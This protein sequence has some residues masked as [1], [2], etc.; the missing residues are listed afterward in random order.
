MSERQN[1]PPTTQAC[2]LLKAM[3]NERRL[4]VL[5]HLLKGEH[6]VNELCKLVGLSQSALSQHLAKL[7]RDR[8]VKTRRAAQTIYYSIA[9]PEVGQIV[10]TLQDLYAK[11]DDNG[12][13]GFI[14][15]PPERASVS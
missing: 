3:S 7:R 9:A 14:D 1:L 4:I 6:S 5:C 2:Q 10:A 8:V 12:Y 15:A 11:R 13:A